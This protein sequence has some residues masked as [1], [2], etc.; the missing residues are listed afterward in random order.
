MF[1]HIKN[2]FDILVLK[3]ADLIFTIKIGKIIPTLYAMYLL[4]RYHESLLD[5]ISH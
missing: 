5:L 2:I 1:S 3:C 4:E